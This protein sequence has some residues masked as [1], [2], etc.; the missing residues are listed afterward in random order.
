MLPEG[1]SCSAGIKTHTL[2]YAGQRLWLYANGYGN[3]PPAVSV[4]PPA[5]VWKCVS[6]NVGRC[7]EGGED[8]WMDGWMLEKTKSEAPKVSSTTFLTLWNG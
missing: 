5:L 4:P 6:K 3:L 7:S 2:S 8:G 1:S